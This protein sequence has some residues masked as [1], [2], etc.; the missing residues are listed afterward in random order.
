[1]TTTTWDFESRQRAVELPDDSRVTFTDNCDDWQISKEDGFQ[2]VGY[3]WDNH[4]LLAELDDL[5]DV[6]VQY[7][8]EPD[9]YGD[10]ISQHR[11]SGD[12]TSYY[13]FDAQGSTIALT[14]ED[15][16]VTDDY[17][18]DAWGNVLA[19]T[20]STPNPLQYIG[21]L[22]YYRDEDIQ[23][24]H[25]RKRQYDQILGRFFSEDPLRQDGG[26]NNLYP[27]V[28]NDPVNDVDPSG[29]KISGNLY[30]NDDVVY[31]NT[32]WY[33]TRI[34]RERGDIVVRDFGGLEYSVNST[35]LSN[36]ANTY[37]SKPPLGFN[38]PVSQWGSPAWGRWFVENGKRSTYDPTDPELAEQKNKQAR[39][40]MRQRAHQR[41]EEAKRKHLEELLAQAS[42]D[43]L[44]GIYRNENLHFPKD[45]ASFLGMKDGSLRDVGRIDPRLA[46]QLA[47]NEECEFAAQSCG[48]ITPGGP[49]DL[50][51]EPED[52]K[53]QIHRRYQE[54]VDADAK[55][56]FWKGV[57]IDFAIGLIPYVGEAQDLAGFV[58]SMREGDALGMA[59]YAGA[60]LVPLVGGAFIARFV[61]KTL[62]PKGIALATD[63]ASC[64]DAKIVIKT[65]DSVAETCPS[66]LLNAAPNRPLGGRGPNS[67]REF[68]PSKAGG[69]IRQLSTD[70]IKITDRGIDFVERHLERFGP[71][72]ANQAMV[73]RLRDI[74]SGKIKPTQ[75]D[76]N[77]Y[78][79][80]LRESI[81]Y[82]KLGF[83][84]GQPECVD[85][86]YDL[87]N[88]AHTGT[89]EDYRLREGPGVLYHPSANP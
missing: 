84:S 9:G 73:Q 57:A 85:E 88:N 8:A 2:T 46:G 13:A 27:Y 7:T 72:P 66:T 59:I 45:Q 63:F 4:V 65:T 20:G 41:A 31:A 35:T 14:D 53:K 61:R 75:T 69:P 24:T 83:P 3:Q 33:D 21:A 44:S 10:V 74:A 25:V 38:S 18:Y 56:K 62:S 71:D 30:S 81:R 1:M 43:V 28:K 11:T 54:L 77:F 76:L 86:A 82:K 68:D 64:T 52:L 32:G 49:R 67:G 89:L 42:Q 78:S 19:A 29:E 39:A 12:Q 87:W 60:T 47:K 48:H 17:A 23:R 22:G 51:V 34:G 40:Q 37:W 5:G 15:A 55:A 80:E 6:Q 16:N 70:K 50:V 58:G 36:F 79:H 26:D